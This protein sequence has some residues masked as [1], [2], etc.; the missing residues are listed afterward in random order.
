MPIDQE[1][2]EKLAALALAPLVE[3]AWADGVVTPA[4]RDGVLKATKALGLGQ[5]A[6]FCRSTLLRWLHE[7]PPTEALERWRRLLGPMLSES[8]SR[9]ALKARKR[10]LHEATK[11][12]KSEGL[13]FEEGAAADERAGITVEEKRVLDDL[14]AALAGRDEST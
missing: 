14:A 6:E 12:A 4:E 7:P 10:L 9:P 13:N 1:E 2:I 8:G 11:I 5:R 3:V